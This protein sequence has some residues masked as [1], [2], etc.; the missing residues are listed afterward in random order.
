MLAPKRH[1]EHV[2]SIIYEK[3][4]GEQVSRLEE[5][6]DPAVIYV[7]DLVMCTHKFHLKK[8][9]PWLSISFEPSAVLGSIAHWGL[10]TVLREKGIDVEVE[11]SK[12]VEVSGRMYKVKGRVDAV[13]RS[14]RLVIEIKT[15]R[16]AVG[17]P[18]EHHIK[19]LNLY[20]N[21]LGFERGVLLYIT[22]SR[23]V[24]YLIEAR[25]AN[26]HEEVLNL[27]EDRYHPRYSWECRYCTFSK[28][29]PYCVEGE[30]EEIKR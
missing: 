23:L 22:P 21:M 14:N 7:T 5:L 13:D 18:K 15:A 10:G 9:Y 3:I 12:E 4:V 28:L 16:A 26:L 24:E 11:T 27:L 20:L 1:G 17:L 19:Q 2:T 8:A 30:K 29:C 6:K 25:E